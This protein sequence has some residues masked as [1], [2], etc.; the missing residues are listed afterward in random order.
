MA[1]HARLSHVLTPTSMSC[2]RTICLRKPFY[3][4]VQSQQ[5]SMDRNRSS[6]PLLTKKLVALI[7]ELI[8]GEVGMHDDEDHEENPDTSIRAAHF[9]K[10]TKASQRDLKVIG[11]FDWVSLY[12]ITLYVC[13]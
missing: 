13:I 8:I 4:P 11:A 7:P 10:T 1:L 3:T 5:N 9:M 2:Y 6:R 12:I